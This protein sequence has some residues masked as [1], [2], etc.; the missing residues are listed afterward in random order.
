M[1]SDV[2]SGRVRQVDESGNLFVAGYTQSGLDGN[3][4]AGGDDVFLVK[5]AEA[6][7]CVMLG[8]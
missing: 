2:V 3:T 5:W 7:A 4:N 1:P 8:Q 6:P